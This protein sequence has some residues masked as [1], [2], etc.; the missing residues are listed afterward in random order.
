[1]RLTR[2]SQEEYSQLLDSHRARQR[3]LSQAECEQLLSAGG[4]TYEQAK[5]GAYVYLH[6][7]SHVTAQQRGSQSEHESIL[8]AFGARSKPPQESI[9][10]LESLGYSYGQAKTA[11]YNYR[12]KHGLIGRP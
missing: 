7:G 4:A 1:M 2:F 5:N 10:H 11:V 8:N 3:G 6:H 9:R 12:V